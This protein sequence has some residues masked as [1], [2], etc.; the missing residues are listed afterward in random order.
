MD[1]TAAAALA[2]IVEEFF[3]ERCG[4]KINP[5]TMVWLELNQMTGQYHRANEV[6]AEES[7]GWFTFGKSCAKA[8]LQNNGYNERINKMARRR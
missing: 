4:E 1:K 7:Q 5:S 6:P 2:K 3:C 8:V